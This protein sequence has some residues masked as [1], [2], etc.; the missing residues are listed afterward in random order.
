M[1]VFLGV[2][3]LALS[4]MTGEAFAGDPCKAVIC[5]A[6]ELTGDGGGSECDDALQEYF[7]IQ[8]WKHGKFKASS[9]ASKRASFLDKCEADEDGGYKKKIGDKFGSKLGL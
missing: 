8:V 3:T 9:T 4:L 5:L 6:G 1:K 2:L 7:G